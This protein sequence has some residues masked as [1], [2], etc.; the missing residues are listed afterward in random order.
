[1]YVYNNP[2]KINQTYIIL[3][4]TKILKRHKAE[5]TTNNHKDVKY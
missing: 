2:F 1:M 5:I 4:K 3:F